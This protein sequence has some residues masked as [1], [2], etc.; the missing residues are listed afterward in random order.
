MK[1]DYKETSNDLLKRIEI[2][3]NFGTK[4]IDKWMLD[5]LKL[6]SGTEIL[7]IGCGSGKQCFLF[8]DCLNGDCQIVGA[9][10]SDELLE[11]A[12]QENRARNSK[13]EFINL[14]FNKE[15]PMQSNSFDLVTCCFAIYYAAN[16]SFTINEMFKVLKPS[17]RLF[18]TGPLPDNKKVFYDIIRKAT[19]KDIPPMP[20]SS[21]FGTEILDTIKKIFEKTEMHR[22]ENPLI[23]NEVEP[24][25]EY[26]KASLSEDRKLW[27]KIFIDERFD[28]IMDR[29][30]EAATEKI[31]KDGRIV[32]TKVVGGFIAYKPEV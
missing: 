12:R 4:D 28:S 21:R 30:A 8:Y 29:I 25:L 16:A 13:I 1:I 11:K 27:S 31:G 32:M 17:G 7:D 23:F 22:F 3:K 15:F 18:V 9:D 2:H 20:G 19:S 14:D 26:T 6:K 24:F 10:V 5:L